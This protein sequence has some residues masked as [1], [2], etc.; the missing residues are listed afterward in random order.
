VLAHAE[1]QLVRVDDL[2]QHL[3][4][5]LPLKASSVT[6]AVSVT[7]TTAVVRHRNRL[8][9]IER[10]DERDKLQSVSVHYAIAG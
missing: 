10:P 4:G 6:S 5:S 2:E 7:I 1:N 3:A 8:S 9:I